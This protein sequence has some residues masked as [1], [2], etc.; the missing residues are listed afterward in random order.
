M[1][2]PNVCYFN[3]NAMSSNFLLRVLRGLSINICVYVLFHKCN[4]LKVLGTYPLS[5][6][7]VEEW[8]CNLPCCPKNERYMYQNDLAQVIEIMFLLTIRKN[9]D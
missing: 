3:L 6:E 9:L 2:Q 8:G 4:E 7:I 5:G 1:Q